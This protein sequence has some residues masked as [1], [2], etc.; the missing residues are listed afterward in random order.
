MA[1]LI[2]VALTIAFF[3]LAVL[4]VKACDRIIGPDPHDADVAGPEADAEPQE[5]VSR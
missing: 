4:L 1:D 3:A 2:F 5:L